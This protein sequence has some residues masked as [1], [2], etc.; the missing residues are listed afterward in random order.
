[1][2]RVSVV[3][4]CFNACRYLREA[5]ASVR[6]QT[7]V[8]DELI[9]V[10]DCSTDGSAEIARQ[11]GAMVLSNDEN[12][13]DGRSRNAG[14]MAAS[15]DVICSLDA[16]D[17]WLPRHVETVVGLLEANPDAAASFA[18]VQRFGRRNET[19]LGLVPPG[20]P[21]DVLREAFSDW[22]HTTI[23]SC[24]RRSAILEIGGFDE[25]ERYS[26]DF[27]FWLRL[28]E[29][30]RFVATHETTSCW[31]W[32]AANQSVH[33]E[34]QMKAVYRFRRRFLDRLLAAGE[35]E[36]FRRFEADMPAIWQREMM[37]AWAEGDAR[38]LH[39]LQSE[40][41]RM[42]DIPIPTRLECFVRRSAREA[43]VVPLRKLG[44]LA[45]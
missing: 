1:M 23:G 33:G 19:I 41:A 43:V 42:F 22:V 45:G 34:R 21:S 30:R 6:W 39:F 24:V 32:H 35:H 14:I 7:R 2:L 29:G 12:S 28:A 36:S 20:P 4:P 9:V 16:D 44:A 3:I 38:K 37:Q 25:E 5:I 8:P 31:R 18:A 10:D 11:A 17:I 40:G 27:D 13:G 15:G 26:V